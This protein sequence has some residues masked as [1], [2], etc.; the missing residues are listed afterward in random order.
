MRPELVGLVLLGFCAFAAWAAVLAFCAHSR[1]N[2]LALLGV[3]CIVGAYAIKKS[4]LLQLA[5]QARQPAL[6]APAGPWSCW[7]AHFK[8]SF[9]T[10]VASLV[11]GW[12]ART[13]L[14]GWLTPS[15]PA[16]SV[17]PEGWIFYFSSPLGVWKAWLLVILGVMWIPVVPFVASDVW[18]LLMPL[19]NARDARLRVAFALATGLAAVVPVLII[20]HYRWP[21]WAFLAAVAGPL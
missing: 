19:T 4:G 15:P 11:I 3:S 20:H 9:A 21:L 8:L 18:R 16:S 17:F 10:F 5:L 2:D 14:I 6:P 7:L 12:F 1:W 13:Q